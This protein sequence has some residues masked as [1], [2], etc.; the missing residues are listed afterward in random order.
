MCKL[1]TS[2]YRFKTM[3][4][5][6]LARRQK[7]ICALLLLISQLQ[8]F[9]MFWE[10]AL[11][12]VT[13]GSRG[14]QPFVTFSRFMATTP[15]QVVVMPTSTGWKHRAIDAFHVPWS[16][17]DQLIQQNIK[18]KEMKKGLNMGIMWGL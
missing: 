16:F 8:C 5:Y 4:V 9:K 12:D 15:A 10:A 3:I 6:K 13:Q 11:C 1:R 17:S 7:A 14:G 18:V 2:L